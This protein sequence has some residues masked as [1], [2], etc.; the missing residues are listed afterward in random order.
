MPPV[1]AELVSSPAR[2]EAQAERAYVL[3]LCLCFNILMIF[4]YLFNIT[5]K[6]PEGY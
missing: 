1:L 5:D 4:I 2:C 6:G 3:L